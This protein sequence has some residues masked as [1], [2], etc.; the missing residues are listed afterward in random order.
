MMGEYDEEEE[1]EVD[2][3]EAQQEGELELKKKIVLYYH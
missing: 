3:N 1:Y 2:P